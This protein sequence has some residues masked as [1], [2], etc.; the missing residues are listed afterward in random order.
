[1][2]EELCHRVRDVIDSPRFSAIDGPIFVPV[3]YQ[4]FNAQ[5]IGRISC[6]F[7]P[8]TLFH[9]VICRINQTGNQV[10]IFFDVAIDFQIVFCLLQRYGQ[11][12]S[13]NSDAPVSLTREP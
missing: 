8:R 10:I 7:F 4:K 3:R 5:I 11:D 1:M 2:D 13:P 6:V 12:V 9:V